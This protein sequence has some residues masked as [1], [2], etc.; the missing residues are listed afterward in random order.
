MVSKIDQQQ[1][2]VGE[3]GI[4]FEVDA[5]IVDEEAER[6]LS[7]VDF[8]KEFRHGHRHRVKRS[9]TAVDAYQGTV[10]ASDE[11]GQGIR[12]IG[13]EAVH[14]VGKGFHILENPAESGPLRCE[15]VIE[16][17]GTILYG[18]ECPPEVRV[19]LRDQCTRF[20]EYTLGTLFSLCI[21]RLSSPS[22]EISMVML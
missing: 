20:T 5:R 17:S 19:R 12:I 10:Q 14:G 8:S 16:R 7:L 3:H 13:R 2:Q 4:Q 21:T 22:S 6:T 9:Q 1:V 18:N 15:N 11:R